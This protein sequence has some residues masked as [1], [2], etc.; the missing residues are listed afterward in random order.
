MKL[1]L[2][3]YILLCK[4]NLTEIGEDVD[5]NFTEL[6]ETQDTDETTIL[7]PS[8]NIFLLNFIN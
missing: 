1:I 5:S 4:Y 7:H 2:K 8:V 6:V 3:I